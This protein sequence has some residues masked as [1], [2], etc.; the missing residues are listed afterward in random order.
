MRLF[1]DDCV[2][3]REVKDVE[4]SSALQR[5]LDNIHRWCQKWRM[6][7]NLEKTVHM[8]FSK[9]RNVLS[10]VYVID[11]CTLRTVKEFRYLGVFLTPTLCWHLHVDFITSKACR[12][13]GFLRRNTTM[14]PQSST[15]LLYKTYVRPIIEYACTVWDPPTARDK[16]QLEKVQN[17]AARYVSGNYVRRQSMTSLKQ[18]LGWETL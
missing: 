12:M 1:A 7:L 11:G 16:A 13:L 9:K 15:D 3:Y 14:F 5:D 2:V 8:C 6:T 17:L 4:D 10:S 18:S